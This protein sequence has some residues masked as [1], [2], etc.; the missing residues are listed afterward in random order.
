MNKFEFA[1]STAS[2]N[3]NTVGNTVM[4]S[5]ATT[6]MLSGKSF[7][8][9]S[10]P[11][12]T[13]NQMASKEISPVL[14]DAKR[15]E[16]Q[17][18]A[19]P[20]AGGKATSAAKDDS[21]FR[22]RDAQEERAV[23][24]DEIATAPST[25]SANNIEQKVNEMDEGLLSYREGRF[26]EA[27]EHLRKATEATPGNLQAHLLAADAYLRIKQPQAALYHAGR[28]LSQPG[29]SYFEDAEWYKALALI[30][31]KEGKKAKPLLLKIK[32]G[33]GKY[34]EKAAKALETL[35]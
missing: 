18:V 1:T 26:A 25:T 19:K 30:G 2:K 32:E 23:A 28:V 11:N 22:T 27:A 13:Q 24:L 8:T 12:Y 5:I 35:D 20:Q 14:A 10:S 16:K 17:K 9:N 6:D 4:D 34:A 31:L 29:N 21:Y 15:M 33:K 3:A 7:A